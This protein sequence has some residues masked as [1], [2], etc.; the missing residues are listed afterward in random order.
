MKLSKFNF[1]KIYRDNFT[2]ASL[3]G[4]GDLLLQLHTALEMSEQPFVYRLGH[5]PAQAFATEE[6]VACRC[7]A[8]PPF[9]LP[10]QRVSAQREHMQA[11]ATWDIPAD[12]MQARQ[13]LPQP[14]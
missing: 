3:S 10:D 8:P 13:A 2:Q 5:H 11:F 1:M 7:R 6:S 9:Y 4:S 12:L 14:V